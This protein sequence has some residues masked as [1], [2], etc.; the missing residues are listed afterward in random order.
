MFLEVTLHHRAVFVFADLP[1]RTDGSDPH[2]LP[3]ISRFVRPVIDKEGHTGIGDHIFKLSGGLCGGKNNLPQIIRAGKSN[4][5]GIGVLFLLSGQ[6]AQ[7]LRSKKLLQPVFKRGIGF[8][9]IGP[10]E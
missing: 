9:L 10:F 8:Q 3:E 1:D 4:E 7:F 5:V 6:D 2:R